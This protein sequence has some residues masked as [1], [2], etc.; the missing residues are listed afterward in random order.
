MTCGREHKRVSSEQT[1]EIAPIGL[2]T[3]HLV[4]RWLVYL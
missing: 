3:H 1:L 4:V 2:L